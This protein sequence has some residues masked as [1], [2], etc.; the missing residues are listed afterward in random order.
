M[1][2]A[3]LQAKLDDL[4]KQI[5]AAETGVGSSSGKWVQVVHIGTDTLSMY[6]RKLYQKCFPELFPYGGGIYGL[7]RNTAL[8]F[9]EWASYLLERV[10][11]EYVEYS[12]EHNDPVPDRE[13]QPPNILRWQGDLNFLAMASDSWKRMEMVC[14][15][16]GHVRRK[17]FKDS[18]RVVLDCTSAKLLIALHQ[19]G[20]HATIGNIMQSSTWD[21][22]IRDAISQLLFLF[23]RSGWHGWCSTAIAT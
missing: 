20:D 21:N 12:F 16:S 2:K 1:S 15:A 3:D 8:T 11:L 9:R 4:V 13:F 17:K 22:S 10:E 5:D 19:L 6:S 23:C 14:L 18:L 7:Q